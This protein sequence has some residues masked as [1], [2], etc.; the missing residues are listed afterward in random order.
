MRMSTA[1]LKALPQENEPNW[2]QFP[3]SNDS[4][5]HESA[6]ISR[7]LKLGQSRHAPTFTWWTRRYA[8]HSAHTPTHPP[9]T[10]PHLRDDQRAQRRRQRSAL[11]FYCWLPP[12]FAVNH[13]KEC[14]RGGSPSTEA[15]WSFVHFCLCTRA[16]CEMLWVS[17]GALFQRW[18]NWYGARPRCCTMQQEKYTKDI[19]DVA[20]W[21]EI[22]LCNNHSS[23]WD[24]K[25]IW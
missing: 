2:L 21:Q 24:T 4:F 8:I 20:A 7:F 18:K 1:E 19:S 6:E 23:I 15:H 5:F 10:V 17:S 13:P 9:R 12:S 3:G 22:K 11:S 25:R 14:G 16:L